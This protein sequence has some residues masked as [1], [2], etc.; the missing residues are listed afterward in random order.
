MFHGL[1]TTTTA[2]LAAHNIAHSHVGV[3][4]NRAANAVEARQ[5]TLSYVASCVGYG[6]DSVARGL[7]EVAD[8]AVQ[9][10]KETTTTHHIVAAIAAAGFAVLA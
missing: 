8:R 5:T 10:A 7:E 4:R 2:A 1:T 9:G 3:A 6:T